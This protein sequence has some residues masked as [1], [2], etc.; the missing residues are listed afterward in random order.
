M[1]DYPLPSVERTYTLD[2]NPLRKLVEYLVD[3]DQ[4]PED[5]GPLY[6]TSDY[7]MWCAEERMPERL[8]RLY[9][10]ELVGDCARFD[11]SFGN[12]LPQAT[13]EWALIHPGTRTKAFARTH[14]IARL[15]EIYD[16]GG[17]HPHLEKLRED[18]SIAAAE[19]GVDRELDFNLEDW[20]EKKFDEL[21]APLREG[22]KP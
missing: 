6:H 21:F 5:T 22:Y 1:I 14:V 16:A 2:G 12:Y 19:E 9:S 3:P 15:C 13:Y 17:E 7:A 10:R 4:K 20:E 18:F 8:R 11:K